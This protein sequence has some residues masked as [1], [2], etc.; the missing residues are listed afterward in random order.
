M[1]SDRQRFWMKL[2]TLK[3]LLCRVTRT[4]SDH[5]TTSTL[6]LVCQY[7]QKRAPRGIQNAFC[8]PTPCQSTDIQIL[9]NDRLI[10]VRVSFGSLEMK[11]AA[12]ALDFQV[13][14]R[15]TARHLSTAVAT[16]H[17]RTQAALFA[18]QARLTGCC[19]ARVLDRLP[20]TIGKEHLQTNIQTDSPTIVIRVRQIANNF[21]F[22]HDQRIPMTIGSLD[23]VGGLWCALHLTMAF[24]FD[25]CAKFTGYAQQSTIQPHIFAFSKLS[26]VDTVSLVSTFEPRKAPAVILELQEDLEGFREPVSQT[27][28]RGC[29]NGCA[30]PTLKLRGQV[31]L[32]QKLG[33]LLILLFLAL[34]HFVIEQA[35]LIQA[36]IQTMALISVRIETEF[37]G[38]HMPNYIAL[39]TDNQT[40]VRMPEG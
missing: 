21:L 9:D 31:I 35:R 20:I 39:G 40:F 2:A 5:L 23:Q 25:G 28:Y 14:L 26:Q 12:L 22:T 3:A 27:L 37:I 29:R 16:L 7:T 24:Y 34:K 30:A 6:S 36:R 33:S 8:Q 1:C 32:A 10:A 19:E 13:C 38:L 11:V 18:A 15:R 4:Y 17:T